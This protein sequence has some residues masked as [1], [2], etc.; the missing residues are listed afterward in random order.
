MKYVNAQTR[1]E[2]ALKRLSRVQREFYTRAL[3]LFRRNTSWLEFEEFAFGPRSPLYE[4]A[5]SH[6]TVLKDPLYLALEDMWLQLGVQ[7]GMVKR[8]GKRDEGRPESRR[9]STEE[10]TDREEGDNLATTR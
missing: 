3:E 2:I 4:S 10:A 6:I 7:Q 8:R 1:V 9:G 5:E